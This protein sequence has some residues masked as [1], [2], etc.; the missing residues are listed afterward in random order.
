MKLPRATANGHRQVARDL[1]RS[2]SSPRFPKAERLLILQQA[3]RHAYL[4]RVLDENPNLGR[5]KLP[6]SSLNETASGRREIE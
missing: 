1:W 4:A 5:D 3:Q 6:P 2:A